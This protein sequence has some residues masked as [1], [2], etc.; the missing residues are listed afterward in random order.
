MPAPQP[1]PR[2]PRR[3]PAAPVHRV[4]AAA[5]LLGA[6]AVL[7]TGCAA[8]GPGAPAGTAAPGTVGRS[9]ATPAPSSATTARDGADTVA[10]RRLPVYWVSGPEGRER[11]YRELREAPVGAPR[12]GA[13]PIAAAAQLMASDRPQDPDYRSL[14]GDVERIGTSTSPDGTITV[15]LPAAAV[16]GELEPDRAELAVQQLVHTVTAAAATSG[17]LPA[18]SRPEVVVLVEGRAGQELFGAVRPAGP[19]APDGDLEAPL[20]LADPEED[21]RSGG[22]LVLSGR[23]RSGVEGGRW[24]VSDREGRQVAGGRIEPASARA[25]TAPFRAEVP[26][27]PGRY[28]VSVRGRAGDAA[29]RDDKTVEVTAS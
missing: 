24:T 1:R 25:G 21:A 2:R 12:G 19:V 8:P 29:V 16:S 11:L 5:A 26:L 23:I 4:R 6:G 14:W 17:L 27:A 7:L 18:S 13:D 10:T 20:W 15:D 22:G 3:V 9:A 28:T